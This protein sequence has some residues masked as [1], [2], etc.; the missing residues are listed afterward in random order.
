MKIKSIE[1]KTYE[2]SLYE[3]LNGFQVEYISEETG[4]KASEILK[5]YRTADYIFD[6]KCQ[7]LQGP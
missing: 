4:F 2:I 7:E 6:L 3:V 1:T 5:D